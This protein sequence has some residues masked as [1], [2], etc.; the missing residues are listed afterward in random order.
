MA[1]SFTRRSRRHGL[2]FIEALLGITVFVLLWTGMIWLSRSAH[3]ALLSASQ[4]RAEAFRQAIDGC[5][6]GDT[7]GDDAQSPPSHASE[8][9]DSPTNKAASKGQVSRTS[10]TERGDPRLTEVTDKANSQD[11]H[12]PDL[13]GPATSHLTGR[14]ITASSSY[15]TAKLG[16][17]KKRQ[18]SHS[19]SLPCN[20]DVD[21]SPLDLA[22]DVFKGFL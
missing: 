12:I 6:E 2:A 8:G 22:A 20:P 3:G 16:P 15:E 4:A 5:K 11:P 10:S 14:R 7:D 19:F 1:S 21:A 13:S 17:F 18:H 9:T